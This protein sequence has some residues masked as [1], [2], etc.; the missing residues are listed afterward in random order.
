MKAKLD[1][2]KAI[3]SELKEKLLEVKKDLVEAQKKEYLHRFPIE[4]CPGLSKNDVD[5]LRSF[6]VTTAADVSR[7]RLAGMRWLYSGGY[8]AL[9]AWKDQLLTQ[10]KPDANKPLAPSVVHNIIAS[11]KHRAHD[12]EIELEANKEQLALM[13]QTYA[14]LNPTI[15]ELD[16]VRL[17]LAN[18]KADLALLKRV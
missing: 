10:F 16:G 8:H 9:C 17:K 18:T 7:D 6:A 3:D 5:T 11:Y 14:G 13:E 1:R 4:I 15:S 12:L 2:Y